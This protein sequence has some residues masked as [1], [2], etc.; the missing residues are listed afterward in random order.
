MPGIPSLLGGTA[1]GVTLD[2]KELGIGGILALA[3]SKLAGQGVVEERALAAHDFLG[4][5]GRF[6]GAGRIHGLADDEADVLG[7]LVEVAAQVIVDHAGHH[8]LNFGVAEFRFGLPLELR[9]REL[10]GDDGREALAHVVAGKLGHFEFFDDVR[11]IFEVVVN[12]PRK[13]DPEAGKMRAALSRADVIGEGVH[14]LL[15]A[16]GVLHGAVHGDIFLKRLDE[17]DGVQLFLAL[18]QGLHELPEAAF[19]VERVLLVDALVD[20]GDGEALVEIGEFLE[21]FFQHV[22]GIFRGL[23]DLG[24]RF[25]VHGGAVSG[26]AFLDDGQLVLRHAA[27]VMLAVALPVAPHG[28]GEPLGKGVDAGDA[29][30]VQA[31]GH[32]VASVVEFAAGVEDGHDHLNGGHVLLG[33]DVHGNAAAVVAY[34][35][36]VVGMQGHRDAV[37]EAGHG[38][39]DGVVHHFV[40]KVVQAARVR[41]AYIHGRSLADSGKSFQDGDGGGCVF[42]LFRH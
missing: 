7:V 8:G 23:E 22:I 42:V 31:A 32:L 13:A 25:E 14:G 15:V 2:D 11:L 39:V 16:R 41:G 10:D 24:I 9:I 36:A 30:A 33:M 28:D 4:P 5:A 18:V 27:R 38:F 12:G 6:P 3:V 34:G 21:A 29:H 1:C 19:R 35:D 26:D 40:D 17:D 37:T 20:A